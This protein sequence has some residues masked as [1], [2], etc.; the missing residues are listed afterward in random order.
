MWLGDLY[1]RVCVCHA[2]A[3]IHIPCYGVLQTKCGTERVQKVQ[4]H[5]IVHSKNV[6]WL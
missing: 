3:V 4:K 6:I 2:V 1:V 5:H